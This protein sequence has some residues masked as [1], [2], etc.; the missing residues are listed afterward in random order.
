[1]IA[2]VLSWKEREMREAA[3]QRPIERKM[4]EDIVQMAAGWSGRF[5]RNDIDFA[6]KN[7]NFRASERETVT[8]HHVLPRGRCTCVACRKE[9]SNQRHKRKKLRQLHVD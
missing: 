8:A 3:D 1:M 5:C 9:Q 2:F 4:I 7:H 6:W